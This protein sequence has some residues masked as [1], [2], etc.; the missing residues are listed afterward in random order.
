MAIAVTSANTNTVAQGARVAVRTSAGIPYV[1]VEDTT[2]GGIEVWKGDGTTPTSFS[3]QDSANNPQASGYGSCSAAIDSSDVIHIAYQYY[4][5]KASELRY[6]TFDTSTDTFGTDTQ[7]VADIGEDP[8]AITDLQTATAVDS[9]DVPHIVY[10]GYPKVTGTN[11]YTVYYI[12]K[13]GGSWNTEV[14]VE[15]GTAGVDCEYPDITIDA[16][17][18]PCISYTNTSD[19]DIG[20]AI[21]NAN[22]ATSFT[23]FDIYDGADLAPSLGYGT[24]SIAVDSS[25]NHQVAYQK[26]SGDSDL[27]I[28]QH[29]YGDAWTTWQSEETVDDKSVTGN[30]LI[31]N[32]SIAIDGTDRYI[33]GED[34]LSSDIVYYSDTGS[35]WSSQTTLETGTYNTPKAKWAFWVDNDSGGAIATGGVDGLT[36]GL[37]SSKDLYNNNY[38]GFAQSFQLARGGN[39]IKCKFYIKKTGAPTGNIVAKLYAITGTHGTDAKPTGSPLVSSDTIDVSTLG[40][41]YDWITFSFSTQY[42]ISGNTAYCIAIEYSGGDSSNYVSVSLDNDLG[43]DGN[44]SETTDGSTWSVQGSWDMGFSV[45]VYTR[46]SASELDYVFTDETDSPDI[47]WNTLSVGGGGVIVTPSAQTSTFS[48]PTPTVTAIKNETVSPGVQVATFS[49]PAPTV[50]AATNVQ[51]SVGVQ[52]LVF[53]Q[54]APNVTT[55]SNVSVSAGIQALTANQPTPTV[56]VVSNIVVSPN[57]QTL[58]FSQPAPTIV[59]TKNVTVSVN[60]QV[61]QVVLPTPS[62]RLGTTLSPP[63]QISSFTQP[64]PTISTTKNVVVLPNTQPL[65]ISQPSLTIIAVKNVSIATTVQT[66]TFSQPVP[67]VSTTT[68]IT[69]TSPALAVVASQPTP[70]IATVQNVTIT[71][72]VQTLTFGQP[73]PG[74]LLDFVFSVSTQ[75]LTFSQPAPT[76][77]LSGSVVVSLGV[78]AIAALQPVLTIVAIQSVSI[79]V[80]TQS[81]VASQPVPTISTTTS[82]SVSVSVQ[83]TTISQPV[84]II[85]TSENVGV[86]VGVLSLVASQ[87]VPTISTIENISV[88]AGAALLS[89]SQPTPTISTVENI[90]VSPSAL[91]I[92]AS[93]PTPTIITGGDHV[94]LASIQVIT[95]SLPTPTV[96]IAKNVVVTVNAVQLG[97]VAEDII[98]FTDGSIGYRVASNIY[99][100]L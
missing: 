96:T 81:L 65:T 4:N 1:I 64:T 46:T 38:E 94:C 92:T 21:G 12:N 63:A 41:S 91:A 52:S 45:V 57:T 35:G 72:N 42:S 87:P 18:K 73:S 19:D 44:L 33:F 61:S 48:Q 68:N 93:Q 89:A 78:Q 6:I 28:R 55:A 84:P 62:I 5:G 32:V 90:V 54:P 67:T 29:N 43:H 9:N 85:T 40:T 36:E 47:L 3:E 49:Q 100:K 10:I 13:V 80:G 20:T 11:Y 30:G 25:G 71:P 97:K 88:L 98:Y 37:D 27:A 39:L 31:Y 74:I 24:N 17:D 2:D 77:I 76:I 56:Q 82:V 34:G 59:A 53:S 99:I 95:I 60:I 14:E 69:I 86:S 66:A 50:I 58:T 15:G 83:T 79:S 22:N 70:T 26:G 16:N 23:L 8:G 75:T 51:V 7:L